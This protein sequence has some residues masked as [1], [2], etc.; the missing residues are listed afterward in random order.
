MALN[1]HV[2]GLFLCQIGG[3]P[4]CFPLPAFLPLQAGHKM[5][6]ALRAGLPHLVGDVTVHI[7]RK[8]N[9]VVA[10]VLL[11]RLD[12]VTALDSGHGI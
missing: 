6:H 5:L 9:G 1:R 8:G 10:Q 11:H 3:F 7:K 4:V 2:P 12:I